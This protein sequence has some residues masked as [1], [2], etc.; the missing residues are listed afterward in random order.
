MFSSADGSIGYL[1]KK[2]VTNREIP[3]P[4]VGPTVVTH[5]VETQLVVVGTTA[6]SSL[7]ILGFG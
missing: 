4:S 1:Y 5:S 7:L 2:N 3:T 6:V